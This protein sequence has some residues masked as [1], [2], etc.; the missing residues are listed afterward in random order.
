MDVRQCGR[1]KKLFQY[2]GAQLCPACVLELDEKF[3]LVR[4]YIYENPA[5]T[6]DGICESTGVE[7]MLIHR[8]LREGRLILSYE[9]EAMLTCENCGKP[10]RTGRYCE[11]CMIT[12]RSMLDGAASSIVAPPPGPYARHS[13][14]SG[15]GRMH[16]SPRK[17]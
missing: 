5:A 3:N 10:L 16:V 12:V 8:W 13:A 2:Q 17:K 9:S 1:C 11:D 6:L 7:A 15:D 4:N 14:L